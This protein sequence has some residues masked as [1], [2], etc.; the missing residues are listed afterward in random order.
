MTPIIPSS[1][2]F[3]Q[4]T[5]EQMR[6]ADPIGQR[7]R[8]RFALFDWSSIDPPPKRGPGRPAH[9]TSAYLK[10]TLV[11]IS[12]QLLSTP[13]WRAY[14]LDHPL[15]VLE[16]G[17]RPHLDLTQPYG[18]HVAKTVPRVRHLNNVLKTLDPLLLAGLFAQSVQAL[19]REIAGLGEVLA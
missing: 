3:D 6:D 5:L 1:R 17:F 7:Y 8:A 13:R 14:L 4:S 18:F 2:Q 10:A 9:P 15:L 11:R 12:E 16:L 19:Q